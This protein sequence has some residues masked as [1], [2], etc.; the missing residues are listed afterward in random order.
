MPSSFR[1]PKT[2]PDWIELDY[3]QRPRLLR[4]FRMW[5]NIAIFVA[6]IGLMAITF[7]PKFHFIY[8]S[9]PVS[10]AHHMFNNNCGVCHEEHFQ[11]GVRLISGNS[12]VRSVSDE[13]CKSCH[14][15]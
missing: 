13:T 4:R 6:V 7:W 5:M 14:D 1:D 12:K 9:R 15:G 10:S 2:L 11:P 8:E 3:Y